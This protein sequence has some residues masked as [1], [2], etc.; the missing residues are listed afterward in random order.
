ME[1]E[2]FFPQIRADLEKLRHNAATLTRIAA[3]SGIE[4]AGVVKCCCGAPAVARAFLTGGA[5]Q[6]ADSRIQNLKRLRENGVTAPLWLLRLPMP[7]EAELTVRCADLSLNSSFQTLEQLSKAAV[8]EGKIHQV[9]LM[10]DLG[11]RREGVQPG[12]LEQLFSF[13]ESLPGLYPA[14]IGTNLTCYGGILP[15]EEN[16]GV[17]AELTAKLERTHQRKLRYVSAGNSSALPMLLAGK[18]PPCVNHLRCGE[19]LLLGRETCNGTVIPGLY[20]DAFTLTAEVIEAD[21][22]PTSPSGTRGRNAFGE[23]PPEADEGIRRRLILGIGREDLPPEDIT[24]KVPGLR[25]LGASSDHLI[26]DAE[27]C[28]QRFKPGDKVEFTPGYSALLSVMTS[29]YV[30][31]IFLNAPTVRHVPAGVK[32]IPCATVSSPGKNS[33]LSPDSAAEGLLS[34]IRG[35]KALLSEAGLL[36]ARAVERTLGENYLPIVTGD[37]HRAVL[38][39]ARGLNERCRSCGWVMFSGFSDFNVPE[40]G[41][42]PEGTTLSI[43]CGRTAGERPL[44][45]PAPEENI[46]LIGLR[47][48]DPGERTALRRSGIRVFTMEEID[49]FGIAEVMTRALRLLEGREILMADFVMNVLDSD[50]ELEDTENLPAGG[51]SLREGLCALEMLADSERVA[52]AAFTEIPPTREALK[53]AAALAGALTGRKILR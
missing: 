8:R 38:E 48:V 36:P 45:F 18:L 21:I 49:R 4:I 34:G 33:F 3:R 7:D 11:D 9:L 13:A 44:S 29:P 50:F 43:L 2:T 53:N 10:T 22:K 23:A 14:G 41:G 19:S 16:M 25:I 52:G 20:D 5:A 37:S 27:E 28:V 32:I 6:I 46:V 51:L 24:P 39:L 47:S 1:Q 40:T 42:T 15:D 26:A 35:K 17:L 31:K 12:D 30:C